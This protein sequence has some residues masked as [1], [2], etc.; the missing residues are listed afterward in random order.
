MSDYDHKGLYGKYVIQKADGSPVDP[1]AIYFTMR[2]DTDP[3]SAKA[4][5]AYIEA[6]REEQPELARDLEALLK[7]LGR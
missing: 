5:R 6:C 3:F 1:G 7:E 4:I 2:I